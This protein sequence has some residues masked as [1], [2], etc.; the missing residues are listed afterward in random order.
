MVDAFSP[1]NGAAFGSLVLV[2]LLYQLL[3]FLLAWV[4]R[5]LFYVPPDFQWGILVVSRDARL[6]MTLTAM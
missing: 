1:S 3:G 2:A 4:C 5:E 6:R